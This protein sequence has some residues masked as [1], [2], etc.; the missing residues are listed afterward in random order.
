MGK[1]TGQKTY[2]ITTLALPFRAALHRNGS[3]VGSVGVAATDRETERDR[4]R[5]RA[6][7]RERQNEGERERE[8]RTEIERGAHNLDEGRDRRRREA[9]GGC[10]QVFLVLIRPVQLNPW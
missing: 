1:A 7:G 3:V 8:R 6:I 2:L 9:G 5:N 10:L 4:E